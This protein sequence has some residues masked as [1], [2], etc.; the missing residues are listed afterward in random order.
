[1]STV[2]SFIPCDFTL[3]VC[4]CVFE[5][6]KTSP[7]SHVSLPFLF[8]AEFENTGIDRWK[9]FIKNRPK[10]AR[11]W[12]SLTLFFSYTYEKFVAIFEKFSKVLYRS[13]RLWNGWHSNRI[14]AAINRKANETK[15]KTGEPRSAFKWFEAALMPIPAHFRT[16]PR[17]GENRRLIGLQLHFPADVYRS[18]SL[19]EFWFR[20]RSNSTR[21][22]QSNVDESI[23]FAAKLH[24]RPVV[25]KV[26]NFHSISSS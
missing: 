6:G 19:F 20:V 13:C 16:K 25:A 10:W 14:N 12:N 17:F 2:V 23:R 15:W 18:R 21:N 24:R 3:F 9:Y 4:S 26:A 22:G 7:F 5:R 11:K 1:M 8:L